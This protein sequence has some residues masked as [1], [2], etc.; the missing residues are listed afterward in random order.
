MVRVRELL[1]TVGSDARDQK[2]QQS[3]PMLVVESNEMVQVC[4]V[5]PTPKPHDVL[6]CEA[7]YAPGHRSSVC[8]WEPRMALNEW[9]SLW[10]RSGRVCFSNPSKK[11][12]SIQSGR[13]WSKGRDTTPSRLPSELSWVR[14][15][16]PSRHC[17]HNAPQEPCPTCKFCKAR[18]LSKFL[19]GDTKCSCVAVS[20]EIKTAL[21]IRSGK[22]N[23]P[24]S[25][26]N[27]P[28]SLSSSLSQFIVTLRQDVRPRRDSDQT[29]GLEKQIIWAAWKKLRATVLSAWD[30]PTCW[31][32][33][34]LGRVLVFTGLL[35]P[36][37]E[38][39]FGNASAPVSNPNR[40]HWIPKLDFGV[41]RVLWPVTVFLYGK[42]FHLLRNTAYNKGLR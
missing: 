20:S 32:A 17:L 24:G 25:P 35:P 19:I 8:L 40:T 31:A 14:T 13:E 39:A 5:L 1:M 29:S 12:T 15:R 6:S 27:W 2:G 42:S 10:W 23:A 34:R 4:C 7:S 11:A 22:K 21:G 26:W 36:M 28:D 3:K 16:W 33:W 30:T 41:I 9:P 37:L 18:E 38:W